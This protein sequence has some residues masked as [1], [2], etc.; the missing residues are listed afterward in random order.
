MEPFCMKAAARHTPQPN[1]VDVTRPSPPLRTDH[2]AC[3]VGDIIRGTIPWH[4]AYPCEPNSAERN[5]YYGGRPRECDN[6]DPC[7]ASPYVVIG[8]SSL[9]TYHKL[10]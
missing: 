4:D 9:S 7:V 3:G 6:C 5:A 8:S 10:Y 1:S 2:R